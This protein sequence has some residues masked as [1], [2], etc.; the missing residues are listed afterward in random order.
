MLWVDKHRPKSLQ[1]LSY[2]PS[3]TARLTSLAEDPASLP[4]LL[5]YG[6]S[7]AG[8]KTRIQSLL[9]AIFGPGA[10]RLRLDKRTFTT[11]T[12]KT[13]DINMICS[14]YHIE[15]S[16]GDAGIY[17]R[18]VVQ[19]VIK[20]MA[21]NRSLNAGAGIG[22]LMNPSNNTESDE[23]NAITNKS[24][25]V[26]YKIVVL[27]EV[28]KLS[29]QAQAALRRTMEKYSASCRLI[30]CC[31]NQ[32]K[33]IE[34]VRSRCL[35]IRVAAPSHEDICNTLQYIADKEHINLPDDLALNLA[36]ES[37]RN[38]RRAILMFETSRVNA[39]STILKTDQGIQKTDWELY[40]SQ[41][42]SDITKEQSPQR[43]IASREKLYELLIN[44]IPASVIIKT[45]AME[46]MKNLDDELKHEVIEAAAF[47]EH[48]IALGSKDIFHL[49]AF[50]AKFMAIYKKYLNDMFA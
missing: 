3:T 20:E 46:L 9:K 24:K 31:N 1:H 21:A 34:P 25:A 45:L 44:C 33:V 30:L 27:V 5:F 43:L 15:L 12:K 42:A 18:Y 22:G 10:D 8:K 47:Y 49:E 16:P 50:V 23:T 4:H 26:E 14:N 7:G 35:G 17:D 32:S 28:D 37:S 48:R 2:H 29:R 39:G 6:P 11:P 36:K 13:L 40:V 38:L 41:L 19:D